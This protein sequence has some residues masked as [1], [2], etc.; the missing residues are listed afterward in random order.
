[1]ELRELLARRRMVRSFDGTPVE[2]KVRELI[3]A[4]DGTHLWSERYDRDMTDVFAIQD[5][6]AQAISEALK[7]RL[8]PRAHAVNIEAYQNYL[9][10]QYYL[11]YATPERLAKAK[12]FFEQSLGQSY[13]TMTIPERVRIATIF[14]Y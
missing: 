8:A 4:A 5:E 3:H 11:V 9:K 13:K 1:M 14:E 7:V 6:I 2:P 12:E 10:G